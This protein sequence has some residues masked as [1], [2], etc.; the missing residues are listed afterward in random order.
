MDYK[1]KIKHAEIV[2]NQLLE[3][4]SIGDI[5][6][7][8]SAGGLYE[9]DVDKVVISAKKILGEKYQPKIR[10]FLLEDK[11]IYGAE[12]FSL[13]DDSVL[14]SLVKQEVRALGVKEKRN[15]SSRIKA[16]ENLEDVLRQTDP[17]F[18]DP[19]K[20]TE[21][22]VKIQDVK[23]QNS[24]GVRMLNIMGGIGMLFLTFIVMLA[25]NRIFFILPIIGIGLIFKGLITQEIE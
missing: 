4:K 15:I 14:E 20:A 11:E 17:R 1:T 10:E 2:A 8:L 6:S 13:I 3:R 23:Q 24:G 16:G 12:E 9:S 18:I 19:A 7:E 21:Y 25:T 5:K 22:A